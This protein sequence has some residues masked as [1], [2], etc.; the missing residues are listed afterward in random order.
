MQRSKL[1]IYEDILIALVDKPLTVDAVAF[2]C[3]MDCFALSQRLT[4]LAEN[5]LVEE[6]NC[7]KKTRY[8]LTRRGL[9][10]LKTLTITRKLEK[11]QTTFKNVDKAPRQSEPN[12]TKTIKQS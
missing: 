2:A 9:A 12:E 10:I 7:K 5:E 4:F 6:T 1:E 3:N 11:L 8:A